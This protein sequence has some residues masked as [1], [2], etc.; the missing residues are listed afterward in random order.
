MNSRGRE[1]LGCGVAHF[2]PGFLGLT[3][4]TFRANVGH[5]LVQVRS[6]T[7]MD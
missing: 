2:A 7:P 3:S 4:V 6:Y 1:I 5:L